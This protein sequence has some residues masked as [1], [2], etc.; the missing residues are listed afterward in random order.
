[1]TFFKPGMLIKWQSDGTMGLVLKI[2]EHGQVNVFW[3][4]GSDG[5]TWQESLRY[6]CVEC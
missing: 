3:F 6:N 2:R 4:D 5:R 1:M